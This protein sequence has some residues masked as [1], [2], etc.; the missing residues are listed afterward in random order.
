M[1][2]HGEAAGGWPA[3][4]WEAFA[5]SSNAMVVLDE[6]RRIVD[7]NGAYLAL[8]GCR[9]AALIRRPIVESVLGGPR[10]SPQQW[11]A[12]LARGDFTG[13]VDLIRA[14]G[15]AVRVHYVARPQIASGRQLALFV[16]VQ[17]TNIGAGR[18]RPPDRRGCERLSERQLEIV[19][20][21]A[22]GATGPEIAAQL[23][24]SHHT[25]RAHIANAMDRLGARSRAQLVAMSLD[26][27]VALNNS[28][29]GRK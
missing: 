28:G 27:A 7:A 1:R 21:I 16:G 10:L 4:F 3:L 8:V 19:R 13:T 18:R 5:R 26:D 24:V 12:T 2:T 29:H 25:V 20:L 23:H 17:V 11:R 15:G 9:R 6:E 22:L 14:D